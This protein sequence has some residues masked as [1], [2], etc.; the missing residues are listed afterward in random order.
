MSAGFDENA[1][2]NVQGTHA[3]K[4]ELKLEVK[5]E[6][7][8][9]ECATTRR[10]AADVDEENV[11]SNERGSAHAQG[12]AQRQKHAQALLLA[13]TGPVAAKRPDWQCA[14]ASCCVKAKPCSG[15]ATGSQTRPDVVSQ[16]TKI[17]HRQFARAFTKPTNC[18]QIS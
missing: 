7:D 6:I 16:E 18:R 15:V 2:S 12:V 8:K 5:R 17:G 3:V 14:C 4:K 11:Q 9:Q 1:S 10:Q 13:A